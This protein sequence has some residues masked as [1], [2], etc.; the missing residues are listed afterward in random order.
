MTRRMTSG[1]LGPTLE[2]KKNHTESGKESSLLFPV[3]VM[4]QAKAE[5]RGDKQTAGVAPRLSQFSTAC[6]SGIV[7]SK[8]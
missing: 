3:A 5:Y 8:P 7:F 2:Y 6:D 1:T 4:A